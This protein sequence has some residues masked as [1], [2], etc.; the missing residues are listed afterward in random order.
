MT[1]FPFHF[2]LLPA[3]DDKEEEERLSTYP[4]AP[5]MRC[6]I[7]RSAVDDSMPVLFFIATH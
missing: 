1:T 3:E 6:I 5:G 4:A 7:G 2:L